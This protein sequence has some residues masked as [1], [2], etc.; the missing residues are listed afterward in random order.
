MGCRGGGTARLVFKDV[1]VPRANLVG[2]L[3]GAYPVFTTMM[4]PE[5]LGTAAMTVGPARAALDIAT[6]HCIH[7]GAKPSGK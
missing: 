1:H 3:H 2:E 6:L 5:R 4:V 7:R